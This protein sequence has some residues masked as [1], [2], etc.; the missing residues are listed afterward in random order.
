MSFAFPERI[1]PMTL[2]TPPAA[3]GDVRQQPASRPVSHGVAAMDW[4]IYGQPEVE[5]AR[6]RTG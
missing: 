4:A 3:E 6:E 1:P 2:R 5:T